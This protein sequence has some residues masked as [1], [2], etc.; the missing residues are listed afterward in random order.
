VLKPRLKGAGGEDGQT[1]AVEPALL[2]TYKKINKCI[3]CGF[4]ERNCLSCGLTLS[5]RTRITSQR[6]ITR[7]EESGK[8]R[9][10]LRKLRSEYLYYGDETCAGDGL[11]STSCPMD[12]NTADLTHQIRREDIPAGGSLWKKWNKAADRYDK[13]E[14]GLRSVMKLASFGQTV[15][16]NKAMTALGKGLHALGAPLWTTSMPKA[17]KVPSGLLDGQAQGE[18]KVVY[19]PSCMNQ[20]M[21]LPKGSKETRPLVEETVDLIH[22]AG[23]EVIFPKNMA[24]LCCGTIWES[25]GMPEIADK[26]TAEV[27]KAL[28]E[29]SEGGK[30]PVLCD[31]SPCLERLRKKISS[32]KLYEP[33]EFILK[34]LAPTLRFQKDDVPVAIHLT[35][36]TRLM[37]LTDEMVSL[38]GLCSSKVIVPEEIGCCGFAGDKGFFKPELNAYAL[39]KLRGQVKGVPVGYSNSR[40]CEIGLTTNSGIPYESIVY[41]VNK[42]TEARR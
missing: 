29:A 10:R 16:G 34:F 23:W 39:R 24:G 14:G 3:E 6:E 17:Y 2:E 42:H 11:C 15:I 31:Q 41:L 28:L 12:I 38:A 25:K 13:V 9:S 32:M 40:T 22:K 30:Y 33:A 21:G 7:L 36:S 27:E 8:D 20:M 35:C 5:P 26:K 4:C 37:H 19:L 18:N 1:A